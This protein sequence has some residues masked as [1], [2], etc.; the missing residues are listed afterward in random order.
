MTED[1][2]V[3][4]DRMIQAFVIL[5]DKRSILKQNYEAEDAA[6]KE[7][8]QTVK[9]WLARQMETLNSDQLAARGI[10]IAYRSIKKHF[11]GSDWPNFW[12][13][14]KENDRFDM[15]QKR[16]GEKAVSEYLDETGE[17][18]PGISMMQ[19]YEIN[20]RSSK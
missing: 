2:T 9:T 17:L 6:L 15:M 1:A 20:V 16:V 3:T 7:K 8:Q 11:N 4:V 5:R 10:G 12:A 13:F 18:P 19:E 14:I